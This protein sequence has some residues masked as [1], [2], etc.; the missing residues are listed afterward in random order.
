MSIA[1]FQ[2][3]S[4]QVKPTKVNLREFERAIRSIANTPPFVKI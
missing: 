2:K 1:Y 4:A 3:L